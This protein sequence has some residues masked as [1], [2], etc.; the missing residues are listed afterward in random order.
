MMSAELIPKLLELLLE[1]VPRARLIAM[2]TMRAGPSHQS[3]AGL[4][5]ARGWELGSAAAVRS[6]AAAMTGQPAER[7]ASPVAEAVAK[8]GLSY[9]AKA[10]GDIS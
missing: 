10:V 1:L 6:S 2:L 8:P 5:A 9:R 3:A 4:P 7:A